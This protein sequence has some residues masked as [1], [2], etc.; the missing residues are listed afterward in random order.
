M[1]EEVFV[2][3][4]KLLEITVETPNLGKTYQEEFLYY[5][6]ILLITFESKT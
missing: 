6:S 4:T 5:G 3:T 1:P 2:N